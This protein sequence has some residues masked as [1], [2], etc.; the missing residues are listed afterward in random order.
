ML[1][2]G[3]L[4]KHA[5]WGTLK[6]VAEKDDRLRGI[7]LEQLMVRAQAQHAQIEESRLLVARTAF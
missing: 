2:L 3:I 1:A 4:G 5:L 7:D 6:I